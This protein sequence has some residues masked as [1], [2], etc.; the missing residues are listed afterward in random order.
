M[1][2]SL[3]KAWPVSVMCEVTG[4]SRSSYYARARRPAARRSP[5]ALLMAAREIHRETRGSYGSRRMS[6][7]LRQRGHAVGRHR[8]RSLM[9]EAQLK[10]SRPRTHRYSKANGEALVAPNLLDRNFEP[11]RPNQVWAGDITYV[12]TRQGWSYL[13]IVM[14]LHSRCIVGWAFA[15]QA[16]TELVIRAMEQ[17]RARRRPPP[18]L[19]FHSDQGCQYTSAYFVGELKAN[20]MVQSMSRKGNCWDN[21]VVERFFR[22]LKSEWLNPK[23]YLDHAEAERD[24]KAYIDDF[25]NCRRIHSATN[26]VPP[27]RHEASFF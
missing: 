20:D 14:D 12:S 23:G 18:G 7:A 2:R 24:I 15:L 4:V 26:G 16:D 21:A 8:A 3:K 19:M 22:S 17:A 9:S 1:I 6:Q 10:V 5:A 11:D 25:Y 13:A 27:V